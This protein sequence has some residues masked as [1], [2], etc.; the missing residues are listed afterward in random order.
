MEQY[1]GIDVS[2]ESASV[3]V[4]DANGKVISRL[5]RGAVLQPD[6]SQQ[7]HTALSE[8]LKASGELL[9][10]DEEVPREGQHVNRLRV[11]ARW[12]DGSTWLWTAFRK[13]VGRG[14]GSSGLAFDQLER[15]GGA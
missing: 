14:E 2:L 11:V 8:V 4:V 3:C 10:Y 9:L 5:R 7:V 12:I 1:A 6:G 13:Q 15:D